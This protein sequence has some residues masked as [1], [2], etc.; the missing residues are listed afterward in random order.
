M[1]DDKIVGCVYLEKQNRELYLGMLS[2]LPDL[3]GKNIGKKLLVAAEEYAKKNEIKNIVIN[4]IS[5]QQ[6]LIEWYERRGYVI[7]S[8]TNPYPTDGRFG[9]PLEKLVFA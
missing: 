8:E 2:V 3:Q 1:E 6:K 4:V 7:T 9:K 5:R